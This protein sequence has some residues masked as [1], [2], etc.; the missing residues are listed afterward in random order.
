[1]LL[2]D[3][4]D[5]PGNQFFC[6]LK[7]IKFQYFSS[8]ALSAKCSFQVQLANQI[9]NP[10]L[11]F[12]HFNLSFK[13]VSKNPTWQQPNCSQQQMSNYIC[14]SV[15]ISKSKSLKYNI[16]TSHHLCSQS[17]NIV[18]L[19]GAKSSECWLLHCK[20]VIFECVLH[21]LASSYCSVRAFQ[22]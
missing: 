19:N 1:M 5:N 13:Y 17:P 18:Q 12:Q 21:P 15:Q 22:V 20:I 7:K 6:F 16:K 4:V 11:I 3:N 14:L 8:P 2:S 10:Q 9:C